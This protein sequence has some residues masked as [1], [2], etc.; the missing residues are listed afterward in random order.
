MLDA[1]P[2]HVPDSVILLAQG[3]GRCIGDLCVFSDCQPGVSPAVLKS[4]R[5]GETH[6]FWSSSRIQVSILLGAFMVYTSA[7]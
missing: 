7:L 1:R 5:R 6:G 4:N 2:D 3:E